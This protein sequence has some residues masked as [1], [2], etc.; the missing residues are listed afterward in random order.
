MSGPLDAIDAAL[1][2][3]ADADDALRE[4]VRIL[5]AQPGVSWAGVA[6]VETTG[7]VLGPSAGVP[8]EQRRSLVTVCY[9]DETVGELQVDGEVDRTLLEAVAERIS[10]HVLLGW[11]TGGEGWEP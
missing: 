5:A 11:D 7:L 4:T 6:F 10:A 2:A 8:D 3:A 9:K 1:E